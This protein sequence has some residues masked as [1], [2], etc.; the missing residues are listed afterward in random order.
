MKQ[1]KFNYFSCLAY[2]KQLAN[3]IKWF[4][5]INEIIA[6]DF[7]IL[8]SCLQSEAT[9]S[10]R[11]TE[12]IKA[13]ESLYNYCDTMPISNLHFQWLQSDKSWKIGKQKREREKEREREREWGEKSITS[14]NGWQH[15][16]DPHVPPCGWQNLYILLT[17]K[18]IIY[19]HLL[20][21]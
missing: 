1:F 19:W 10:G 18:L 16:R 21:H 3:C 8:S 5:H 7:S 12:P 15:W 14:R 2:K 17:H 20:C 9:F 11:L 4:I 13:Q 6:V